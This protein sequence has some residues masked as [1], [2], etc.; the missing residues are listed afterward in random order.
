MQIDETLILKLENLARLKL[1]ATERA[2]IQKDLGNILQMVE[3]L[4]E[5]DLS[6]VEPLIYISEE[7]NVLRPDVVKH[8]VSRADALKNAPDKNEAYFKVP[9]VINL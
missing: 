2:Q 6:E 8:Q 3:K 1:S 5:L 7:A 4:Q 9:K